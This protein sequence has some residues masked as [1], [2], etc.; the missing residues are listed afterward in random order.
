MQLSY[1]CKKNKISH[2]Y[3]RR[4]YALAR[5]GIFHLLS[6]ANQGEIFKSNGK[7]NPCTTTT[8]ATTITTKVNIHED[9]NIVTKDYTCR[10]PVCLVNL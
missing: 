7:N 6:L 10:H 5:F 2:G 3:Q 1:L 9:F 4:L 8:T